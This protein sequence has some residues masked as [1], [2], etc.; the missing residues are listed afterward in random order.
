MNLLA[1]DSPNEGQIDANFISKFNKK[2]DE[3]DYYV[4]RLL[5]VDIENEEEPDK[6]NMWI[7]FING[8]MEHWTF[9]C[10]NGR[11]VN[12]TDDIEWKYMKAN[13]KYK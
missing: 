13:T 11:I 12:N 6:G 8:K 5:G 2:E 7:P 10:R 9:I 1:F 3:F 4:Q